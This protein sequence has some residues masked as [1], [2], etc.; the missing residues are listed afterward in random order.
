VPIGVIAW[1]IYRRRY[2]EAALWAVT[3]ALT[4]GCVYG[5]EGWREP[6]MFKTAAVLRHPVLEYSRGF[7]ILLDAIGQ[8]VVP[9]A[10]MGA[11]LA[12]KKR[13]PD[14]L[15]LLCYCTAA[16]LMAIL[17]DPQAGGTVNYFWESLVVSAVL[18]GPGLLALQSTVSRTSTLVKAMVLV[19]LLWAF[20]PMLREE[21]AYLNLCRTNIT[22]YHAR[23]ARWE[24]FASTISGRRLLSTS[25]DIALLSSTPEMV[26]PFL[27]ATLELRGGF[28]SA[29]IA[30]Q[31]NAG[32]YD[33]IVIKDG[34]AVN[35]QNDYRGIRMWSEGMW[36]A[37][38]NT[39]APACVFR[40]DN[41]VQKFGAEGAE[42]VWLPRQ[43]SHAILPNLL[44]IGC[45]PMVE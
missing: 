38:Q 42:E 21:L 32:A 40:D 20:V 33:L 22:E 35:H 13:T 11:L 8:P 39:Y 18:A 7:A 3:V 29:P 16:W 45:E 26:D 12:I 31:I 27:N 44:A 24:D 19:L 28:N 34:E 17:I 41:Y 4:V 37:L 14:T 36:R 30:A 6:L 9:F 15:L 25:S 43:D 2:K 1:L 5:I 23:K 10:A